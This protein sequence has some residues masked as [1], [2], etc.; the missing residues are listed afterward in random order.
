MSTPLVQTTVAFALVMIL[1]A[2]PDKT[3]P[4]TPAPPPPSPAVIP[5]TTKVADPATRTALNAFDVKAGTMRFS[6]GTPVVQALKPGDVLVGEPS[7]AAPYGYLRKVRTIRV[8]NGQAVLETTQANLT[9]A[10][11]KGALDAKG[12]LKPS[13]VH[14]ARSL[15]VGVKPQFGDGFDYEVAVHTVYTPD[16]PGKGEVRIDGYVRFNLGYHVGLD[17]SG[18]LA[19]PPVC[20]DKFEAS[21]G[22]D[23]QSDLKITGNLDTPIKKDLDLAEYSFDPI[24]FFIGPVPVVIVP[25]V[26]VSVGVDGQ[27]SVQ[28]S[29]SANEKAKLQVGAR[30]TDANGWEDISGKDFFYSIGQPQVQGSVKVKGAVSMEGQLLLYDVAGPGLNTQLGLSFDAQV[31]R[32]PFWTL[33][34]FISEDI[35]FVVD[36]PVIGKIADYSANLLE[37]STELARS[38]NSSPTITILTDPVKLELTNAVDLLPSDYS[39]IYRI[40]DF[41]DGRVTNVQVVSDRDGP[42]GTR[43]YKFP[44]EGSRV[45]T[46]TATDSQGASA[47]AKFTV[48]VFNTPP[49]VS[50]AAPSVNLPVYRGVSQQVAGSALEINPSTGQFSVPVACGQM[51]WASSVPSDAMPS[52]C[53]GS[54][55]FGTNGPRTLTLT[56]TGKN[57]AKGQA[58]V[59]ITVTDPPA[60]LSPVIDE[61]HIKDSL[62]NEIGDSQRVLTFKPLSLSVKAHDPE[63]DAITYSWSACLKGWT[64]LQCAQNGNLPTNPDGSSSF[65]PTQ[66]G[67]GIY[68]FF[69]T[70]DDGHHTFASI[71]SR[72]IDVEQPIN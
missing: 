12:T 13:Q 71:S 41:E 24:V 27:A 37:W 43:I 70:A 45:I 6:Q 4:P 63:N 1:S 61:M 3:L 28:F 18:C 49:V 57:G 64:A 44:N 5:A 20:L 10:I 19:L 52:S 23:Q 69:V 21:A 65:D 2:C 30:W 59:S 34:A 26:T 54:A 60:N 22:F 67:Y 68:T 15:R 62:G 46:V 48:N 7:S 32:N 66:R 51:S 8:E 53:A 17:I 39:S 58:S 47:S 72:L 14:T 42:I 31:P 9:D 40:S 35:T 38:R 50:I 36:L 16:P 11:S 55:T 29:Y 25:K 33:S 56:A